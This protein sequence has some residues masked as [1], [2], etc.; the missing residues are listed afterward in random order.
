M[1]DRNLR[2]LLVE[3][4]DDLNTV[5]RL[6]ETLKLTQFKEKGK[7]CIHL[8]F[9]DKPLT[10]ESVADVGDTVTQ[11]QG[12]LTLSNIRPKAV[13]LILDFDAP[14]ESEANNRDIAVRDVIRQMQG[15]E[16]C[17]DIPSDFTV[18]TP[19]GFIA[20]PADEDT[21]R[22]GVWLM[23][24]NQDRGMLE[25]F[26]QQ[27]IPEKRSNLLDHARQSTDTAKEQHSAPSRPSGQGRDSH[28]PCVDEQAGPTVRCVVPERQ[29]RFESRSRGTV[30]RLDEAVVSVGGSFLP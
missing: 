23:P 9:E 7:N 12:R 25:T 27:L 24:N 21:P 6:L 4:P 20:E 15:T 26:L 30:R 3:G 14:N 29:L 1:D 16:G 22:I 19:N 10:I 8:L 2:L 13:G 11:F 5:S 28:I 17:W 18:L